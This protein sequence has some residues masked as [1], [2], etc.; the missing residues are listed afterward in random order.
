MKKTIFTGFAVA[1]LIIA[2]AACQKAEFEGGNAPG[3]SSENL[4]PM[5]ITASLE[6]GTKAALQEGGKVFWE[7]GDAMTVMAVTTD[8]DTKTVTSYEF[9]TEGEGEKAEFTG[10][11]GDVESTLTSGLY[12]VYPNNDATLYPYVAATKPAN[13]YWKHSMASIEYKKPRIFIPSLQK[14]N[15]PGASAFRAVSAGVVDKENHL[16]MKNVGGLVEFEINED[17]IS[18][19]LFYGNSGESIAGLVTVVFKDGDPVVSSVD[20]GNVVRMIPSSGST[21]APGKYYMNIPPMTFVNGVSVIFTKS[22]D[23]FATLR[24][25]DE[26]II[27]RSKISVLPSASNLKYGG[28][29]LKIIARTDAGKNT[30]NITLKS[31]ETLPGN[32]KGQAECKFTYKSVEYPCTLYATTRYGRNTGDGWGLIWGGAAGDY[33]QFPALEKFAL[34]KVMLVSGQKETALGSPVVTDAPAEGVGT[35]LVE[36]EPWAASIKAQGI[37]YLWSFSGTANTAYRISTTE[38]T[39]CS[40][41]QIHLYYADASNG[42]STVNPLILDIK[43]EPV[44]DYL[45]A[46]V[47]MKA[48]ISAKD[49]SSESQFTG[50]FD[51]RSSSESEWTTVSA[52]RNGMQLSVDEMTFDRGMILTYRPWVKFTKTDGN[53]KTV[54]GDECEIDLSKIVLSLVF[55]DSY[56]ARTLDGKHAN[57]LSREWGWYTNQNNSDMQKTTLAP[58]NGKSYDFVYN[59]KGYTFTFYSLQ[60]VYYDKSGVSKLSPG[61][62]TLRV[63]TGSETTYGLCMNYINSDNFAGPY[64]AWMQF[65]GIEGFRLSQVKTVTCSKNGYKIA[66]DVVTDENESETVLGTAKENCV[67]AEATN[68]YNATLDLDGTNAGQRYYLCTTQNRITFKSLTLTYEYAGE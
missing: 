6:A 12:A 18:S 20:G 29:L 14:A 9:T 40:A 28:K 63:A 67:I 62:Y 44:V 33:I 34:S 48:S 36:C 65:P 27:E 61:G 54:Y 3:S 60:G 17:E 47:T 39:I 1:T 58:M 66:S 32:E 52:V 38:K 55:N 50:G 31:G 56:W 24:S 5:T 45:N 21:F 15:T 53:V 46:K 25:S 23:T 49:Y 4:V 8:G 2:A 13:S 41:H 16:T 26:F 68:V 19:V 11:V 37:A 30:P 10:L 59:G 42:T 7:S 43:P 22:N 57:F 51:Y 64:P 35:A